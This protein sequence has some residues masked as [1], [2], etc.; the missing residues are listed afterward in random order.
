MQISDSLKRFLEN[1]DDDQLKNLS[2]SQLVAM[3]N[4]CCQLAYVLG[5]IIGRAVCSHLEN[6]ISD[7]EYSVGWEE[8]GADTICF[9]SRSG[10]KCH[11][12]LQ[13]SEDTAQY[14]HFEDVCKAILPEL[15]VETPFGIWVTA[16]QASEMRNILVDAADKTA[17][18]PLF[19]LI[20]AFVS[21]I[22]R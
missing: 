6:V 20:A 11:P 19:K 5:D 10:E 17:W 16:E 15:N 12:K 9:F 21:H 14:R 13:D 18:L 22:V 2:L 1:L 7:L 4:A 8:A 3:H